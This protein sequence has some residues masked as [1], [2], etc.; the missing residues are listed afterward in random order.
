[1]IG[2]FDSPNDESI[3]FPLLQAA[4]DW[5]I[6]QQCKIVYGPVD[7]SIFHN[8]RFMTTGFEEKAYYG[9]PR[10]HTW[11]PEMFVKFGF[12]KYKSWESFFL[13]KNSVKTFLAD[14]KEDADMFDALDYRIRKMDK[15]NTKYFMQ[16]SY[17]L[18]MESYKQFPLFT[19]LSE[20]DFMEEFAL[21][22]K[23][24]DTEASVFLFNPANEF[25]GFVLIMKDMSNAIRSM[26]GKTN[27]ISKLNFILRGR[28]YEYAVL[29][30]GAAFSSKIREAAVLGHKQFKKP[31]SVTGAG[32]YKCFYKCF[33]DG[34]YKNLVFSLVREGSPMRIHT[35]D[36]ERTSREYCLFELNL[37]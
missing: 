37:Q 18:L 4:K 21:L 26:K 2:F 8:Y 20:D 7:F 24:V 17:R 12:A 31:M 36:Y 25:V 14:H 13:D 28:D 6:M 10:N 32:L 1:L 29:A 16:L 23:F 30:Q 15:S 19:T 11:Y 27:F 22:P 35:A 33:E 9:E 3:S 5:L 34:N